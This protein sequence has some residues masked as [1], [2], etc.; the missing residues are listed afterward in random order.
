MT[1][2]VEMPAK[3]NMNSEH[4]LPWKCNVIGQSGGT[5]KSFAGIDWIRYGITSRADSQYSTRNSEFH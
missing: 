1:L 2:N 5:G 4:L 3:V